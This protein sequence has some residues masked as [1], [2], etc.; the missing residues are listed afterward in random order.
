MTV[1]V[2]RRWLCLALAT[3]SIWAKALFETLALALL[4]KRFAPNHP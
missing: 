2:Q 3:A 1:I 4:F